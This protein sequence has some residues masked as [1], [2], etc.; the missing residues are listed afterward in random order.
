MVQ[1]LCHKGNDSSTELRF[2]FLTGTCDGD[3]VPV[4]LGD[5][6]RGGGSL[7]LCL[8]VLILSHIKRAAAW[9]RDWDLY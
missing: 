8:D 7:Y 1:T 3:S 4:S 9:G 2:G 5:G 6:L